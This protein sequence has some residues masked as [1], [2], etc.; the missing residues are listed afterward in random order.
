MTFRLTN[1]TA[2]NVCPS[3]D[4]VVRNMNRHRG[5]QVCAKGTFYRVRDRLGFE[6]FF[7]NPEILHAA[8]L[9]SVWLNAPKGTTGSGHHTERWA[10]AANRALGAVG[11]SQERRIAVL[12]LGAGSAELERELA[13]A[14]IATHRAVDSDVQK[15][16]AA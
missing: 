4:K 11:V 15:Y 16:E 6:L 2:P 1:P 12:R 14:A 5:S 7:D 10:V 13:V 9:P 3:C 8:G